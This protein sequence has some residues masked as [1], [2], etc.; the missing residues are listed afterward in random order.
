[1]PRII[2]GTED[3]HP[4]YLRKAPQPQPQPYVARYRITEDFLL[5]GWRRYFPTGMIVVLDGDAELAEAARKYPERF[6][7][8]NPESDKEKK[9]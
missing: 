1:V 8:V 6:R 3:V 2:K 9:A 5:G 7:L 4:M